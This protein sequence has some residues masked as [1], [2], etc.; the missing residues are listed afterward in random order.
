MSL[1][2]MMQLHARILFIMPIYILTQL[3]RNL[4]IVNINR[5]TRI[6]LRQLYKH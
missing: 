5:H 2:V 3:F 4:T 1:G 6:P